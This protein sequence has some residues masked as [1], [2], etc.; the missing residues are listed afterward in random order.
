MPGVKPGIPYSSARNMLIT[1]PE[2]M[3][4]VYAAVVDDDSDGAAGLRVG[5]FKRETAS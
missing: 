5:K 2:V 4:P 3:M 1:S